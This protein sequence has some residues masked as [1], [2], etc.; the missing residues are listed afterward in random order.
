MR[1]LLSFASVAALLG[2]CTTV[3]PDFTTPA[4]PAAPGYAMAGDAPT[5][6]AAVGQQLAGDWW[7]LFRSPELDQTVRQAVAGNHGLEAARASLAQAGDAVQAQASRL[8]LDADG[9]LAKDRVNLSS[10]GFSQLPIP[11][12]GTLSLSNPTFT[13]Y[14]FGA[15]GSY[16]FDV[17]GQRRRE[18]ERLLADQEAQ[19]YQTDAAYL[20]LT[21]QVV[22]QAIDIASLRAQIDAAEEVVKSDQSNLDLVTKSYQLGGGTRLDVSTVQTELAS[23]QAIITPMRQQLAVARH[24][25]A[26][27][28]GQPPSGFTPPEFDLDHIA[29]PDQVPVELPSALVHDR[30]D[31]RAAEAELHAA[32][33]QIG[34]AT[35]DLYPKLSLTGSITQGALHPSDLFS[36]S[37]TGFLVGPSVSV[38][39]FHGQELKAKKRMAEDEA[40]QSLATYEQTVLKA[41]VQVADSLQAVSHDDQAIIDANNQLA[42]STDSLNL[43][44]LRFQDG[45]TGLLPVLDAQRS[46][47]RARIAAVR[48]R[49]QRLQDT[50]GLLYAVSHNWNRAATTEPQT[51]TVASAAPANH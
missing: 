11:G 35:A 19:A 24:A 21:A 42:A 23:D 50:A 39:L 3:G 10:F 48:A 16:D 20:T 32:T 25:L 51:S 18:R 31:I 30:P 1:R 26:L 37:A 33:A 29:Q 13:I 49:A 27:L 38:P 41:F 2:A 44:R 15:S 7:A 8:K 12:G 6:E 17:F 22:S 4:A 34:V 40:R 28:V 46:W 14:S 9:Q 47:A 5:R 45:K 36:Y 43:Q